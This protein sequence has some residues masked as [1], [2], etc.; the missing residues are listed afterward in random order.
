MYKIAVVEDDI[1]ISEMYKLKLTSVGY[2]VRTAMNGADGFTLIEE[3]QPD[4]VLLDLRMPV[5]TGD[6]MLEKVRQ[7]DWGASVRVIVLTNISKSEAPPAL[8][9][10][11]VDRYVVKAHHTP[12]EVVAIVQ[13]ILR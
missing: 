11:S 8:R 13:E 10:L 12:S 7:T 5:M 9:F 3:F 4:L 6:V 2:Q 1:A